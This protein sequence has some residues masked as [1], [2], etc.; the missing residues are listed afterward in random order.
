MTERELYKKFDNLDKEEL[1]KKNN[2][3]IYVRN[4][5][6]TIV[7]K[8]CRGEKKRNESKRWIQKKNN[9]SRF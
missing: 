3:N 7:F 8:C 6:I 2:K 9:D 1:N 5:V 4:Y